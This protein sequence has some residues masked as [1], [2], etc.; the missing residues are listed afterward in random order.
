MLILQGKNEEALRNYK[1]ISKEDPK[2]PELHYR[3][4]YAA[5]S[6]GQY[7]LAETEILKAILLDPLIDRYQLLAGMI[8]YKNENYFKAINHL[9]SALDL[10]RQMLEAYYYL[11]LS[12]ERT[13]KVDDALK[14]LEAAIDI[15]P[16]YFEAHL[17]YVSINYDRLKS[18]NKFPSLIHQLEKALKL[19]PKSPQ[20]NLLL[21]KLYNSIG[22]SFKAKKVLTDWIKK[23]SQDDQIILELAG[24]EYQLGNQELAGEY[25][26]KIKQHN[27]ESRLLNLKI[28]SETQDTDSFVKE[29]KNL[30]WKYPSEIQLYILLGEIELSRGNLTESENL[31]QKALKLEPNSAKVYF[32]LSKVWNAKNDQQSSQWALSKAIE[33]SPTD[34]KIQL[35]YLKNL[36]HTG[37]VEQAKELIA[38]FNPDPKNSDVIFVKGL[39]AKKQGDFNLADKLFRRAQK[40]QFSIDIELQLIDIEILQGMHNDAEKRLKRVFKLFPEHFQ[41]KMIFTKLLFYR[42][43]FDEIIKVLSPY[44]KSDKV[45]GEVYLYLAEAW[46]QKNNIQRAIEILESG[47]N[48]WPR[49]LELIQAYTFYLG[50]HKQ[51]K[52]AVQLLEDALT[53]KHQYRSLFS[54]RLGYYY[55]LMGD[56]KK[57]KQVA[58]QN[59]LDSF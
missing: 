41:A 37:N 47:V 9:S 18:Q 39:I 59:H 53:F 17:A 28:K 58:Q 38:N 1:R 49:D 27:L 7:N 15:E 35:E 32:Q 34:L 14:S 20:G 13:D 40:Q 50:I 52:K 42:K 11:A 23:Y 54:Y 31:L 33:F 57:F 43:S 46:V 45:N 30:I 8:F 51:Y 6:V 21:A 10:N 2:N 25:L 5:H 26:T 16:L 3:F 12:Y 55:F 36:I 19:K 56:N 29:I 24:M 22:A 48:I 44:L 4:A